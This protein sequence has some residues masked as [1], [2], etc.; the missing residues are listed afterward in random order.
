MKVSA[1][2]LTILLLAILTTTMV[3]LTSTS[4]DMHGGVTTGIQPVLA[5]SDDD[6]D[7]DVDDQGENDNDN[8]NEDN[9]DTPIDI[10][11]PPDT[12]FPDVATNCPLP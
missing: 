9:V 1:T 6:D 2:K 11:I 10:I 8:D 12:C 7:D 3:V 4:I 5:D